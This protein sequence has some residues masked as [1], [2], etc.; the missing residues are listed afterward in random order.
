MAIINYLWNEDSYLEEYDGNGTTVST[1]TNEPTGFGKLISQRELSTTKLFHY[2]VQGSTHQLSDENE[3]ITDEFLYDAWGNE[4]TR[5]GTTNVVFTYI[6]EWGYYSDS[7]TNSFYVR[8]RNYV[9]SNARWMSADPNG[10]LDGIN[11]FLYVKANPI[12]NYDPSGFQTKPD[13]ENTSDVLSVCEAAFGLTVLPRRRDPVPNYT[14]QCFEVELRL[15]NSLVRGIKGPF[16]VL[17]PFGDGS[18]CDGVEPLWENEKQGILLKGTAAGGVNCQF[19]GECPPGKKCCKE[20]TESGQATYD[21][22][23]PIPT[24]LPYCY[25]F[26]SITI[27]VMLDYTPGSCIDDDCPCDVGCPVEAK[28]PMLE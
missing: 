15:R 11:L 20:P 14:N 26:L 5:T 8:A 18:E 23:I 3:N 7:E 21:L 17:G 12:S 9:P 13:S 4:I 16:G 2:D 24:N 22:Y 1:F 10:F 27:T 25:R 6:G 28:K 19:I